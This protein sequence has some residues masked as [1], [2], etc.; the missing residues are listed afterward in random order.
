M[1]CQQF[2]FAKYCKIQSKSK[3][4]VKM[5]KVQR[6]RKFKFQKR[7]GPNLSRAENALELIRE[8]EGGGGKKR[9]S[10]REVKNRCSTSPIVL[11]IVHN[12]VAI[13][14]QRQG[15]FDGRDVL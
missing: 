1:S 3:W 9:G 10:S 8:R 2:Q 14:R 12:A 11:E 6:K 7:L 13:A 4:Q 5:V 15:K